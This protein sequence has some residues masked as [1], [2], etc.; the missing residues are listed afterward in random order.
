MKLQRYKSF[1]ITTYINSDNYPILNVLY[2][3][4]PQFKS[5]PGKETWGYCLQQNPWWYTS[6]LSSVPRQWTAVVWES[7]HFQAQ[8]HCSHSRAA[9]DISVTIARVFEE[10][11]SG[12]RWGSRKGSEYHPFSY[13]TSILPVP[14][15]NGFV[16]SK[17]PVWASLQAQPTMWTLQRLQR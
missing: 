6:R 10:T 12:E 9:F 15:L 5:L 14:T 7:S 4:L 8:C 13:H 2:Y 1:V 11:K 16:Q 3:P 17:P